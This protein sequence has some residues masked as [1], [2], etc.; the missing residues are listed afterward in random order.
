MHDVRSQFSKCWKQNVAVLIKS[1]EKHCPSLLDIDTSLKGQELKND[2]RSFSLT[3]SLSALCKPFKSL[4]KHG[5]FTLL[6]A[7][8]SV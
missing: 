3:F 1:W 8:L 5:P 7:A 4:P 2:F 6:P